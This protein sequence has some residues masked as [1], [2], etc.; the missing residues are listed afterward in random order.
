[1]SDTAT[2]TT[3][4]TLSATDAAANAPAAAPAQAPASVQEIAVTTIRVSADFNPRKRF[5]DADIAEFSERIRASGWVS[6]LLVRPDPDGEGYLLVAGERR[7]RSVCRLGW[8]TVPV[9][10]KPMSDVEHRRLALAENIDRRDL[11]VA[12]E[13]M[14]ARDHLNAYDGD[15][16]AAAKALGWPVA[17]LRHRLKLLRASQ[18]VIEALMHGRIQLGHAELLATMPPDA[19]DKA[20]PRIVADGITVG[21]LRDQINGYATPLSSAIFDTSACANCP[22]NTSCQGTLFEAR[23][24]DGNCT[25]KACFTEKAE[26]ELE[27]R[28]QRAASD[29]GTV[30]LLSQLDPE[31]SVPLVRHGP[32]GVGGEQYDACKSC[33]FRTAAIHDASGPK[34]GSLEGPFCTS[35]GCHSKMVAAYQE[36]L[37][38]APTESASAQGAP[39]AGSAA[40]AK[41]AKTTPKAASP[42]AGPKPR[43]QLKSVVEQYAHIAARAGGAA[44]A[45]DPIPALALALYALARLAS[46]EGGTDADKLLVGLGLPGGATCTDTQHL[47]LLST[48]DQ[49]KLLDAIRV[50]GTEV[51]TA[52]IND[53]RYDSRLNRL[54]LLPLLAERASIPVATHVVV[55][56]AFLGAHTK[57]GIETV[58][59]ESGFKAWMEL[60]PD[61]AKNY[62][63]LVSGK[64]E[65]IIKAVSE[66]GFSF[67]G[68][69]PSGYAEQVTQWR[70]VGG[71]C[72]PEETA[73]SGHAA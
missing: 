16:E 8:T 69:V 52:G 32:T 67:D 61:G 25:N 66:S 47:A 37:A 33:A 57:P 43:A 65:D 45:A 12:E 10:I 36:S 21:A 68:Y 27:A 18:A 41:A 48:Y 15:H 39:E 40:A 2:T 62:R 26:Q 9:T 44:L 5:D 72:A 73:A 23:V 59:E 42:S 50:L 46:R 29:F 20:L 51:L 28:R 4:D 54:A 38:P 30:V 70:T 24:H 63:A 34:Q 49:A 71:V 31:Q 11:T 1:M 55:D 13:A 3:T 17:R 56:A 60:A 7:F 58:L 35:L 6:P 14:A 64:K 19:Q 53:T 22:F